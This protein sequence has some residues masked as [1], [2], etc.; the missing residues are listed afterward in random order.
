MLAPPQLAGTACCYW[1]FRCQMKP[2]DAFVSFLQ[3]IIRNI[4]MCVTIYDLFT[5][6]LGIDDNWN[7]LDY[8]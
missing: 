1:S 6:N 5:S 2:H 4:L 8:P 3:D 7:R